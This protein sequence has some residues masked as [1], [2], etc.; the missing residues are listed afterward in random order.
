V[1]EWHA[2]VAEM[3]LWERRPADARHEVAQALPAA[4]VGDN[5][6]FLALLIWLG[7]RA[8]ADLAE[9]TIGKEKARHPTTAGQTVAGG[10]LAAARALPRKLHPVPRSTV[11][12]LLATAEHTRFEARSDPRVWQLAAERLEQEGCAY[13]AAYSRWRQAEAVMSGSRNRAGARRPLVSAHATARRLGAA[14]LREEIE[15][16]ARRSRIDLDVVASET[17]PGKSGMKPGS[18]ADTFGLTAREADVLTQLT[19]GCTNRQI[20]EA[21]YISEKTVATHVSHILAKLDVTNRSQAAAAA[22]RLGLDPAL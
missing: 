6:Y 22:H 12:L 19:A 21:L 4:Q 5:T 9:Q 17:L 20:A 1:S 10:L 14:P 16:L 18:P 8:E 3:A 7:L 11:H 15:A 2:I 13:L